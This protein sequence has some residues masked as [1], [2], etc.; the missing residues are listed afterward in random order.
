[1]SSIEGVW[2]LTGMANSHSHSQGLSSEISVAFHSSYCRYQAILHLQWEL[3]ILTSGM[4]FITTIYGFKFQD[5]CKTDSTKYP[6]IL[7]QYLK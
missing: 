6:Q 7:L 2:I 5:F 4:I 1:M 3:T